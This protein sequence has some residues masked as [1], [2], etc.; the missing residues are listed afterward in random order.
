MQ[1][2]VWNDFLQFVDN[3]KEKYHHI[4]LSILRQSDVSVSD[5]DVI[6]I[7][8]HNQGVKIYLTNRAPFISAALTE[9]NGKTYVIDVVFDVAKQKKGKQEAPLLE[10]KPSIGDVFAKAGL[11]PKYSFNNFAVSTS[12]QVAYAASQAV[13]QSPG[14]AYNP[15]FLYGGVGVGKTHLAQAIVRY[16]L[17]KTQRKKRSFVLA[18][19]LQ[20]SLSSRLEKKA[21]PNSETSTESFLY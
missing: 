18:T 20:M 21:A 16:I 7:H 13:S 8:C 12:N 11:N 10:F 2:S 17:E 4:N 3:D 9:F 15:L 19:S 14:T 5:K 1:P 6:T